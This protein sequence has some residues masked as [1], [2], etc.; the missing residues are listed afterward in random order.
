MSKASRSNLNFKFG[1]TELLTRDKEL[2]RFYFCAQFLMDAQRC[3]EIELIK[4]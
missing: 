4:S 3:L 1:L 2:S